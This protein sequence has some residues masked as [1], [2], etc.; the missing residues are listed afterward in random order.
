MINRTYVVTFPASQRTQVGSV[1][2]CVHAS[3]GTRLLPVADPATY[4]AGNVT[5]PPAGWVAAN[6]GAAYYELRGRT[7]NFEHLFAAGAAG[8]FTQ[9][10]NL[11]FTLAL[12]PY[13]DWSQWFGYSFPS[14]RLSQSLLAHVGGDTGGAIPASDLADPVYGVAQPVIRIYTPEAQAGFAA[15]TMLVHL[16]IMERKDEDFSP[17]GGV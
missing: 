16:Q 11:G 15:G 4:G 17:V 7:L 2:I 14:A 12:T 9:R 1:D 8:G 10:C 13:G 3:M 6:G 5:P